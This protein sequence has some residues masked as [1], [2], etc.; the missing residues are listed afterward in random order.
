[1]N[2]SEYLSAFTR[3]GYGGVFVSRGAASVVPEERNITG[4][5]LRK[6][7]QGT[8]LGLRRDCSIIARKRRHHR[9]RSSLQYP[10]L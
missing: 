8:V 6:I 2:Q 1:M 7:L 5:L 4:P 3:L 10:Q 9:S